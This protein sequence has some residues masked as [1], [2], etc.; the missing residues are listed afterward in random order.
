ML[1][2]LWTSLA[3]AGLNDPY[4]PDNPGLLVPILGILAGVAIV[5]FSKPRAEQQ[6]ARLGRDPNESGVKVFTWIYRVLGI[7]LAGYAI[8]MIVGS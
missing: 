3:Y 5:A 2:T 4:D 1:I 6:G 8:S 7:G